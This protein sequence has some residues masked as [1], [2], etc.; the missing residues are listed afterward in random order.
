MFKLLGI[1]VETQTGSQDFDDAYFI[2]SGEPVFARA[3]LSSI[4]TRQAV[5]TI[6]QREFNR[7]VLD[8]DG[9][10]AEIT[11]APA[12]SDRNH[13]VLDAVTALY[14]LNVDQP[15]IPDNLGLNQRFAWKFRLGLIYGLGGTLSAAGLW[16]LFFLSFAP[17]QTVLSEWPIRGQLSIFRR[18]NRHLLCHVI[19]TVTRPFDLASAF[20]VHKNNFDSNCPDVAL[21]RI[22]S[23]EPA[24]RPIAG[25]HTRCRYSTNAPAVPAMKAIENAMRRKEPPDRYRGR[26]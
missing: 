17:R 11:I 24:E 19:F 2:E 8:E 15:R 5:D 1:A 10:R 22:P 6:M 21:Y 16:F 9:I 23:D 18:I 26:I 12:V 13:T 3:M 4:K 20:G 25:G 7:V 14:Q